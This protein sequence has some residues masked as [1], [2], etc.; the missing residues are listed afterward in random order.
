ML[1]IRDGRPITVTISLIF[2]L[3]CKY[4][5]GLGIVF[6]NSGLKN[7]ILALKN[8]SILELL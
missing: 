2:F 6:V 5:I 4:H 7:Y 3:Q 8:S 1:L